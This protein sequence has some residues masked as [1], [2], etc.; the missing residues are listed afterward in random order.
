MKKFFVYGGCVS[1]DTYELMKDDHALVHYVARQSLISATSKPE[2]RLPTES[3]P[4]DFNSRMVRGDIESSL[5]Q[6]I[7]QYSSDTDVFIFDVLSERLGVYRIYGGT[8][9]TNSGELDK[10]K[11]LSNLTVPKS[12]IRFGTD[13]HFD[14]WKESAVKLKG[15]LTRNGLFESSYVIRANWTDVTIQG[16]P[17]PKFR[18]MDANLANRMYQRYYDTLE[19]LQFRIIEPAPEIASSDEHHKWGPSQYHYQREF[20]ESI[21]GQLLRGSTN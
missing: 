4:S 13:R 2:R 11:I 12:L 14:L 7:S 19:Q 20:Y 21:V 5:F 8:Y 1:R 18:S 15:H 3:L 9:I 16:T 10:T 6:K 17:T